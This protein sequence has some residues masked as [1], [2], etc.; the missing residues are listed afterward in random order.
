[1]AFKPSKRN[2]ALFSKNQAAIQGNPVR[3][4]R[5]APRS[6]R[7]RVPFGT[8]QKLVED[9]FVEDATVVP[10]DRRDEDTELAKCM[11]LEHIHSL[12]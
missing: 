12:R 1:M 5:R 2:Y 4:V 8:S 11:V 3:Q 7:R 6:R 9:R 10:A